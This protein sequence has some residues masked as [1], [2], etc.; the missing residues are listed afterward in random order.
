MVEAAGMGA[1]L[2][3]KRVVVGKGQL[4]NFKANFLIIIESGLAFKVLL[5]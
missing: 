5:S 3:E 4:T 2:L 1:G